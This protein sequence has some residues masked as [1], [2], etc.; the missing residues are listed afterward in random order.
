MPQSPILS[1]VVLA[2]GKSSRMGKDKALIKFRGEPLLTKICY[3]A[4]ECTSSVYVITSKPDK[5]VEILPPGCQVIKETPQ[6]SPLGP[7]I[8]F[9]QALKLIETPWVLLLACDLPK[10]TATPLQ[11]WS[12]RLVDC[13]GE[14]IAFLPK[15]TAG[16]EPLCGFYRSGCLDSLTSYLESGGKSFQ[17]W[18]STH[19]VE[20]IPLDNFDILFNC[21][22]LDDLAKIID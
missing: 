8:A 18:L 16:W 1:A 21:N 17:G 19:L 20:E 12:Q 2:G 10:L 4:L 6:P 9:S 15:N 3:V 14:A 11:Q 13:P 7:L 22:T 5:Y